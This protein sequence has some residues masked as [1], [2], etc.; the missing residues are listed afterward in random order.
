MAVRYDAQRDA[1]AFLPRMQGKL[2]EHPLVELIREINRAGL[3]GALRL[4]HEHAK[5]VVYF[6]DGN[7]VFATSNVRAHRL[8]E[9]LKRAGADE[10]ELAAY[11]TALS[12]DELARKLEQDGGFTKDKLQAARARQ[13]SDV[14]RVALLWTQGHWQFDD[15]VRIAG[16]TR[17]KIDAP[18]LLL[19]CA[20]HL[21]F[22]FVQTRFAGRPVDYSFVATANSVNLLP[23]EAAVMSRI[24]KAN[25]PVALR[26][27]TNNGA[28]TEDSLRSVYGLSLAGLIEPSHWRRAFATIA[29]TQSSATTAKQSDAVKADAAAEKIELD[30]LFERVKVAKNHYEVLGVEPAAA[31]EEIKKAY[32]SLAMRFHPDHF[33]QRAQSLRTRVESAF[34]LIAQAYETLTNTTQRREYDRQLSRQEAAKAKQ[35]PQTAKVNSSHAEASFQRGAHALSHKNYDDAI[36][37]LA[38]AALLDPRNARYRATY[39]SALMFRPNM[40]RSAETELQAAIALEPNNASHRLLLAELYRQLGLRRRAESELARALA[41]D[42]KNRE[43]RTLLADIKKS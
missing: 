31:D 20:R 14:L 16:E 24:A 34:A 30:S 5:A 41:I 39:A 1:I 36:S 8:R 29:Q 37:F 4:S 35:N 7:L 25:A 23:V 2:A 17:V 10:A 18:R 38:E 19:E 21:P 27:L 12:D 26:D 42:P 22:S 15:R 9:V 33:H 40:K 32:H 3:S 28:G 13:V 6:D 43:A 11:P